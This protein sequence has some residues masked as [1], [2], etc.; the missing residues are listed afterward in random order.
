MNLKSAFS[1]LL[2]LAAVS[3]A[4]GQGIDLTSNQ[5]IQY[6]DA[7]KEV[8]ALGGARLVYGE[9]TL[10]AAEIRYNQQTGVAVARGGI[11]LTHGS[12]RVLADSGSYAT[13]DGLVRLNNVK[14][15]MSPVYIEADSAEGTVREF[16]FT[17]AVINYGEPGSMTPR[18]TSHR[19][20]WR[21]GNRISAS[22]AGLRLGSLPLF[23][24]PAFDRPIGRTPPVDLSMKLGYRS[25]L[26]PYLNLTALT[27]VSEDL[28]LGAGLGLFGSR[29]VLIG[30]AANYERIGEDSSV[31]GTLRSG[32]ISDSGNR[33][34]DIL[35]DPID[36]DRGFIEWRHQQ[37]EGAIS[38]TGYVNYW[39]DSEIIRDFNRGEFERLQQPDTF[40]EAAYAKDNFIFSAFFRVQPNPFYPMQERLPEL[41]VDLLPSPIGGGMIHRG[42]A[43]VVRLREDA[44]RT[45]TDLES[46]RLDLHYSLSRP[47]DVAPWL[48]FTPVAGGRITH[49]H[50]VTDGSGSYTRYVS[51]LGA[52]LRGR[53][54]AE[55]D[56]RNE[57]WGIDGLRHIVE[58]FAQYRVMPSAGNGSEKLVMIDR[59]VF[60]TRLHPLGLGDIRNIDDM[61][62]MNV[63]RAGI[64][65]RLQTRDGSGGSR[66][67]ASLIVAIDHNFRRDPGV[68]KRSTLQIETSVSP[69]RWL[70]F[71]AF[72][73][74]DVD[75]PSLQELNTGVSIIDG[76]YWSIGAS[77]HFLKGDIEEYELRGT[78]RINEEFSVGARFRYDARTDS[79]YEQTYSLRQNIRNLWAI[80][81]QVSWHERL[82]RESGFHFRVV[83]DLLRF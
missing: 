22:G 41:R 3:I 52:D 51:E 74:I 5:P 53:A 82:R 42:S 73:R 38:I 79:L 64:D 46:D 13:A 39:S 77:T 50:D 25:R 20:T 28:S 26:G 63:L 76:R 16:T 35:G 21:P 8:V 65:Q 6:D 61:R 70:R 44:V 12:V 56:Y 48:A 34:T 83:V 71:D 69:V 75:D 62:D 29:G 54:W 68:G 31:I 33:G 80:E 81:Y 37:T 43:S 17:N 10:D 72:S 2:A 59:N 66:D 32:Y 55:F 14:A 60:G 49:Y 4:S 47:F 24:L 30:P 27:P 78:R 9:Y 58:P 23:G 45:G 18:V 19:V 15:G 67:L 1:A 7:T 11:V 57:A 36:R 40:L